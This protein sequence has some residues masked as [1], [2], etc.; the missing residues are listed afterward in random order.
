[1]WKVRYGMLFHERFNNTD[2]ASLFNEALK[3]DPEQ[4]SGLPRLGNAQR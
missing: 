2:A 4:C 1:L 3:Q